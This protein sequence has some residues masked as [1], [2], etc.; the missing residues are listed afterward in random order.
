MNSEQLIAKLAKRDFAISPDSIVEGELEVLCKLGLLMAFMCIGGLHRSRPAT[1]LFVTKYGIP[2]VYI[3]GGLMSVHR[4]FQ[5]ES[6]KKRS[7]SALAK[8]SII[9]VI[10]HHDEV[11]MFKDTL[12]LISSARRYNTVEDFIIELG[13]RE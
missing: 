12:K 5:V 7:V 8:L 1:E 6:N 2:A 9:P 10:A 3:Y 13:H 11:H 4:S